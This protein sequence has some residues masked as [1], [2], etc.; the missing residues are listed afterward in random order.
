M[1]GLVGVYGNINETH[2]KIFRELLYL[3]VVRGPHST[4][5]CRVSEGGS[6]YTYKTMGKPD[7]ML[8]SNKDVGNIWNGDHTLK[9]KTQALIGHNRFATVGAIDLNGAHP[10][11][12]DHIVGAH[13][14]TLNTFD[15]YELDDH[16]NFQ[17]D[18]EALFN[19]VA[20][21][22]VEDAWRC[23]SARSAAAIT[24]WDTKEKTMNL[25][26]NIERPLKYMWSQNRDVIFWASE[27]WMIEWACRKHNLKLS[28]HTADV[29]THTVYTLT[30][31]EK[32]VKLKLKN[33]KDPVRQQSFTNSGVSG[34][35]FKT[36]FH[37]N[38]VQTSVN[39]D[40]SF[41]NGSYDDWNKN[42]DSVNVE[43]LFQSD[44]V[45]IGD[46]LSMVRFNTDFKRKPGY[47]SV[48]DG[49]YID[50][51]GLFDE[52][53][54]V[55]F[56]KDEYLYAKNILDNKS[57][58]YYIDGADIYYDKELDL[59]DLSTPLCL[60]LSDLEHFNEQSKTSEN[61]YE[62]YQSIQ[63]KRVVLSKTPPTFKAGHSIVG[64]T[65][66]WC[67]FVFPKDHE[68][69]Y[70]GNEAGKPSYCCADCYEHVKDFTVN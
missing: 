25:V 59:N 41:A 5:V 48:T 52:N 20:K 6:A 32:A 8:L 38:P 1:C 68:V 34:N 14:G 69:K 21:R 50:F 13:N 56:S 7:D 42:C 16:K 63:N 17:T 4:G 28:N 3:D 24:F 45:C 19:T 60:R 57:C 39:K 67:D 49:G 53:F 9:S 37:Q 35:H 40:I 27:P 31:D 15:I 55:F 61:M 30:K 12:A 29:T 43:D 65:C 54:R 22:G 62:F 10:F 36:G 64:Q 44:V 51:Q 18:S 11:I 58:C 66:V 47:M 23:L 2:N 46:P 33:I 26:R 70:V